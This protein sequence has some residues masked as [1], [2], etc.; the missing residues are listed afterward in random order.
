M[1]LDPKQIKIAKRINAR[2][3][4]LMDAGWNEAAIMSRQLDIWLDFDLLLSMTDD[5]EIGALCE[6]FEGFCFYLEKSQKEFREGY[7]NR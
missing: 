3:M 7:L 2:V 4:E 6:A 5:D 1:S